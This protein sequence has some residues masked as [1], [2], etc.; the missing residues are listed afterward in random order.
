MVRTLP[1]KNPR[2]FQFLWL[3]TQASLGKLQHPSTEMGYESQCEHVGM[4]GCID[5]AAVGRI[6]SRA[7]PSIQVMIP[8]P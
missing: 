8:R 5:T 2:S 6:G 4:F 7:V 1:G 3:P